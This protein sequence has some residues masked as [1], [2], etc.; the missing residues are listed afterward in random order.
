MPLSRLETGTFSTVLYLFITRGLVIDALLNF[1]VKLF[2]IL[3]VISELTDIIVSLITCAAK[4]FCLELYN[5]ILS[6]IFCVSLGL[7]EKICVCFLTAGVFVSSFIGF[8][9]FW[10]RVAGFNYQK[11]NEF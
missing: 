2:G 1:P 5:K 9:M 6:L 10:T 11:Y 8:Y 7:A 4:S 3:F